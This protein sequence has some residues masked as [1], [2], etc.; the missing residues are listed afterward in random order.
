MVALDLPG[1]P[2]VRQNDSGQPHARLP[3]LDLVGTLGGVGPA[4]LRQYAKRA[5][6]SAAAPI[7][8]ESSS[9][10]VSS[11]DADP[12]RGAAAKRATDAAGRPTALSPGAPHGANPPGRADATRPGRRSGRR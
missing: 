11:A 9:V 10:F 12:R 6:P 7:P 1:Y 8:G 5:V 4:P 3:R 2:K